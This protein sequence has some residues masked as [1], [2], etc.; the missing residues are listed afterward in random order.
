MS[1][2]CSRSVVLSGYSSFLTQWNWLPRYNWNI[3][4]SGIKHPSPC[5]QCSSLFQLYREYQASWWRKAQAD[6]INWPVKPPAM[7]SY[8]DTSTLEVVIRAWT[9]LCSVSLVVRSPLPSPLKHLDRSWFTSII[10]D[11][12]QS[13]LSMRSPLLS[14]HLYYKVTFSCPVI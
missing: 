7:A 1:V 8:L 2:T 12:V 6:V 14:C 4:E 3:V 10:C 5:S 13:N 9:H 11:C